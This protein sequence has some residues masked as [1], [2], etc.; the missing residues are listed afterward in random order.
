M[1]QNITLS[2]DAT[3]IRS[4]RDKAHAEHVTLNDLFRR[5]LQAYLGREGRP[6]ALRDLLASMPY[7]DAGQTFSRDER[8]ER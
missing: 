5:W 3:L 7:A 4:A 2:A 6:T 8:N 1:R